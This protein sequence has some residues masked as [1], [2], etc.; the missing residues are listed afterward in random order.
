VSVNLYITCPQRRCS[1]E[2]SLTTRIDGTWSAIIY[3]IGE[4]VPEIV[5]GDATTPA[6]DLLAALQMGGRV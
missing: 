1:F 4:I 3:R 2:V 5:E 6:T